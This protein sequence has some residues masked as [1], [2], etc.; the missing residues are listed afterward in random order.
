MVSLINV[1]KCRKRACAGLSALPIFFVAMA[2]A[3]GIEPTSYFN[4]ITN[5]L[6]I[7][8]NDLYI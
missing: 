3:D 1:L 6:S 4:M 7:I 8:T 5:Y 2:V